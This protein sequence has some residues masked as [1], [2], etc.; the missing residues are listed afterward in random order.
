M[1]VEYYPSSLSFCPSI[2]SFSH[3]Y[4]Q[5]SVFLCRYFEQLLKNEDEC[6]SESMILNGKAICIKKLN[7][8]RYRRT[9]ITFCKVQK[10]SLSQAD[11]NAGMIRRQGLEHLNTQARKRE[12]KWD[13]P[14]DINAIFL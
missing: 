6:T 14:K 3:S 7:E 11:R 10:H 1:E 4:K 13:L 2:L 9:L 8:L 12:R 5:I